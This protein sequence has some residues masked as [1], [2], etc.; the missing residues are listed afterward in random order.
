M[1]DEF[2]SIPAMSSVKDLF[3]NEDACIEWLFE[4]CF[5]GEAFMF[6]MRRAYAEDWEVVPLR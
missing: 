5:G 6:C 3:F 1:H 2:V 4:K